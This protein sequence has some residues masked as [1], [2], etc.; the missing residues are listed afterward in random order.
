M[1]DGR[2]EIGQIT[3]SSVKPAYNRPPGYHGVQYARIGTMQT[4]N[5]CGGWQPKYS[6]VNQW[7]QVNLRGVMWVS[8]VMTQGRNSD[9]INQWVKRFKVLYKMYGVDWATVQ[10][11]N[12]E[13]M[14]RK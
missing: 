3:A 1:E 5:N 11:L 6:D 13:D 2:I 8:G 7:I 4:V 9:K 14:V 12:K 10:E